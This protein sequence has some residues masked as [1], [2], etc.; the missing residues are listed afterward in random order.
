MK[1]GFRPGSLN[2]KEDVSPSRRFHLLLPSE[3]EA[4]LHEFADRHCLSLAA[5]LRELVGQGLAGHE[6]QTEARRAE[7][8]L[9][10]A[11]LLAA[12]HAVRPELIVENI[13]APHAIEERQ[14]YGL[15]PNRWRKMTRSHWGGRKPYN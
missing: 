3:L 13:Q 15:R 11:T 6:G 14:N 12:E 8:P 1:D 7:S 10:L 5:A 4:R 2:S 9:L